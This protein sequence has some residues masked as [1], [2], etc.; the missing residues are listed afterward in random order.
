MAGVFWGDCLRLGLGCGLMFV[1]GCRTPQ[2]PLA[3]PEP[4]RVPT[5]DPVPVSSISQPVKSVSELE[6]WM[7]LARR[8]NL[9]LIRLQAA[10]EETRAQSQTAEG[11]RDPELRFSSGQ[12]ERLTD[13]TWWTPN[14]EWTSSSRAGGPPALATHSPT[15]P[16]RKSDQAQIA[17]RFKPP[18]PLYVSA[19]NTINQALFEVALADLQV[20]EWQ[21]YCELKTAL[22]ERDGADRSITGSDRVIAVRQ[23]MLDATQALMTGGDMTVIDQIGAQQKV[24]QAT[25]QRE[26]QVSRRQQAEN[27]LRSL[28]GFATSAGSDFSRVAPGPLPPLETLDVSALERYALAGRNEISSARWRGRAAAGAVR[29]A[30]STR[31]PWFSYLEASY[32]QVLNRDDAVGS[33]QMAS[34]EPGASPVQELSLDH[35]T[36]EEWRVEI[37]V[38]VPIFSVGPAAT[39]VALAGQRAAAVE[40]T[41]IAAQI[42]GEV[43]AAFQE[44]GGQLRR[45]AEVQQ[46]LQAQ[47]EHI[48]TN[49][50]ISSGSGELSRFDDARLREAALDLESFLNEIELSTRLALLRLEAAVG[51]EWCSLPPPGEDEPLSP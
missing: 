3:R 27:T 31:L 35:S 47:S 4:V 12:G 36:E 49:Q 14:S 10:V 7:E 6:G 43:R 19:R 22:V 8:N 18:N 16:L 25:L 46:V 29:E 15:T 39:R 2:P 45:L 34:R 48:Q 1:M 37:G 11:W 51:S 24:L 33:L 42:V 5:S 50:A 21:V 23:E 30:R 26:R 40:E 38:T 41:Q 32:E 44:Y 9:E 13:R 17:L 20:L 28:A